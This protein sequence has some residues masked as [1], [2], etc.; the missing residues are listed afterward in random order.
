M[1]S[2]NLVL[3]IMCEMTNFNK[4]ILKGIYVYNNLMLSMYMY[5]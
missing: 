4:C 5:V 3:Y 1:T 2:N